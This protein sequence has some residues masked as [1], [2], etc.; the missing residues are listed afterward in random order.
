MNRKTFVL[1]GV[2]SIMTFAGGYAIAQLPV[3]NI[4]PHVHPNL[5]AA[6]DLSRKA[7]ERISAAQTANEFDM[8]GH[9]AKAKD[10][11]DKANEQLRMAATDANKNHR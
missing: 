7:F 4:N 3:E 6:Q 10:F 2:L 5:A 9:A 1:G 8:G 11:L